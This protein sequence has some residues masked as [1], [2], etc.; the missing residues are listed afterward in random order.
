MTDKR[1][2][3][4]IELL[5]LYLQDLPN[6]LPL[7]SAQDSSYGFHA[8]GLDEEW[9]KEE[10]QEAAANRQ[11][12]VQWGTPRTTVAV[13]RERGPGIEAIA[14]V[15]DQHLGMLPDSKW[16][17]DVLDSVRLTFE[18]YTKDLPTHEQATLDESVESSG[19]AEA[20]DAASSPP[21]APKQQRSKRKKID[22]HKLTDIA[23]PAWR[24][25][26]EGADGRSSGAKAHPDLIASTRL[27]LGSS[28]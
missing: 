11:L 14:D 23:D 3:K 6:E 21:K 12:E 9:L 22:S 15:L 19:G 13:L 26:P 1:H 4:D 5:R 20:S 10:G 24:D 28:T 27:F 25:L 16:L 18:V 17:D 2:A 7:R 8:F